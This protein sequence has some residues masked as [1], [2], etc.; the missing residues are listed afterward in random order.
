MPTFRLANEA[1][2]LKCRLKKL[3][4][5]I[6]QAPSSGDK[7]AFGEQSAVT[8]RLRTPKPV[9]RMPAAVGLFRGPGS[10]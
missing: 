9:P 1:K 7:L 5:Y 10:L 4:E 6:G 8:F 2:P 3:V